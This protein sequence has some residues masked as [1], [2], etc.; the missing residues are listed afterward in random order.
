[1]LGH[2]A[3]AHRAHAGSLFRVP[4]AERFAHDG[5][6]GYAR[7]DSNKDTGDHLGSPVRHRVTSAVNLHVLFGTVPRRESLATAVIWTEPPWSRGT[8]WSRQ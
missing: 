1:M 3:L 8:I 5:Y 6:A 4:P 7:A 2:P